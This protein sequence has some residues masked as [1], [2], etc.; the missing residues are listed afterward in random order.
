MDLSYTRPWLSTNETGSGESLPVAGGSLGVGERL[1]ETGR[2]CIVSGIGVGDPSSTVRDRDLGLSG[3]VFGAG[4]ASRSRDRDLDR[5][6]GYLI[7]GMRSGFIPLAGVGAGAA[8]LEG[9]V[10][11]LSEAGGADRC[12]LCVLFRLPDSPYSGGGSSVGGGRGG[13]DREAS[14]TR[15]GGS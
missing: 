11:A 1:G 9:A 12:L 13:G 8:A 2:G 4:A 5:F 15:T 3:L 10:T 14:F 6:F 7:C